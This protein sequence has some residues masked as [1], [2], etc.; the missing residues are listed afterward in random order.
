VRRL[1]VLA[2]FGSASKDSSCQKGFV[3]SSTTSMHSGEADGGAVKSVATYTGL[4]HRSARVSLPSW[5]PHLLSLIPKLANFSCSLRPPSVARIPP[6][7]SARTAV[8]PI[9]PT[10]S[11]TSSM[12]SL[13]PFRQST[14]LLILE[15]KLAVRGAE[16]RA[17]VCTSGG[18]R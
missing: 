8:S 15:G 9:K 4:I 13:R 6:M 2:R 3:Q 12:V 5:S 18:D 7:F 1:T 17:T 10:A 14:T 11:R 16:P